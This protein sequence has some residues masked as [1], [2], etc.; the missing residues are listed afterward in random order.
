MF[1][2]KALHLQKRKTFKRS[3]IH[4]HPQSVIM[5]PLPNVTYLYTYSNIY[6]AK[7]KI[8]HIY[9]RVTFRYKLPCINDLLFKNTKIYM[10]IQYTDK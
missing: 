8:I 2:S 10:H 1:L 5:S 6:T 4:E 7:N 9:Y 3:L